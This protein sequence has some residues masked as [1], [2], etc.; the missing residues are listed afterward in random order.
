MSK[1]LLIDGNSLLFRAY[2]ATAY[3]GNVMRRSD[4][5]ATNAI[6]GFAN[7]LEKLQADHDFT[8]LLVAWDAGKTT[9]RTEKYAD[10]KGTRDSAP[11]DLVP[12]F[13][14]ARQYLASE[15][16][17]QVEVKG[18]EADDIVGTY[19]KSAE[20]AGF[21]VTII[22]GDKDMLQL[23]DTNTRVRIARKGVS[24]FSDYTLSSLMETMGL[25]PSQIIDMKG[26]MG[27]SGDNIPGVPG[28]GEKT[29]LK[30]LLEHKTVEGV[31]ENLDSVKGKLKE[32]LEQNKDLAFMSKELATIICDMEV[33]Y[34]LDELEY[35][36][37][38]FE[39]VRDFFEMM[40]FHSLIRRRVNQ[41][42]T[43]RLGMNKVA[44]Q[45]NAVNVHLTFQPELFQNESTLTVELDGDNYHQASIIALAIYNGENAYY[46]K[47]NQ[48]EISDTVKDWLAGNS[49]KV[50]FDFKKAYVAM[51][52]IGIEVCGVVFDAM[53][54]GFILDSN[55][56]SDKIEKLAAVYHVNLVNSEDVF[57]KGAKY[58][59]PEDS[60]LQAYVV[61]KVVATEKTARRLKEKM[62]VEHGQ[63]LHDEVDLPMSR[64]LGD[65][66]Y[67]GIAVDVPYLQR[68][69]VMLKTEI[70]TLET[71]IHRL[72]GEEFNIASPKQL[73]EVLF[74]KLG[75]PSGKKTKTG[76]STAVDV[77]EK[78]AEDYEI[79]QL[80]LLYRQYTKLQ[81]TY[82]QGLQKVVLQDGRI[83][84]MY[85]QT[86]TQT[87]RLSSVE[88]NLQNIPMKLELGRQIRKAFVPSEQNDVILALDY[89]Q[90]ELR[91][92]A[93]LGNVAGLKTAFQNHRDVHTETASLIF[94]VEHEKV[95]SLMRRQAKAINFGII[96]GMSQFGLGEQLGISQRE[97]KQFIET[98][99]AN[100]PEVETYMQEIID[101]GKIHGYVETILGRRR[102]IRELQSRNKMEQKFGERAAMNAPIQG[103]AADIIKVAMIRIAKR[104]NDEQ[105]QTKMLLQVHDELIFE[106]PNNE[107]E[108]VET[109]IQ[110]EMEHAV[111]L[112]VPLVVEKAAG[113]TWFEAK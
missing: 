33:P 101:F 55:Q 35:K 105:L 53:L 68:L 97:A 4:G 92:L 59:I 14:F 111:S 36:E 64:V 48:N 113:K 15:N 3:S 95:T 79:V 54:A 107:R 65:M 63:K 38:D 51:K 75:L 77:L 52:W 102:Y 28:V 98:Y 40:E 93:H 112:S 108:K 10:Y 62:Q 69:E 25:V 26:L 41:L 39:M 21:E 1:L 96:Y 60:V 89:S 66:E 73:G 42:G 44:P 86:L 46:E 110:E 58:S 56:T 17:H 80:I 24:E 22:T 27:D 81:S 8:H 85:K 31:Y 49:P 5:I 32:K 74:G 20:T 23:V 104:L 91:I 61:E 94:Q 88:P 19:A 87:G 106:V 30:L 34:T 78:L 6:F 29:A 67:A 11:E 2:F 82:V 70:E 45:E 83:H 57:G 84:T 76:Y 71:E 47:V 72:A 37:P 13:Q 12:Q 90:I 100:L 109:L 99:N 16:I 50:I 18:F 43:D 7:M 103:S 9:F